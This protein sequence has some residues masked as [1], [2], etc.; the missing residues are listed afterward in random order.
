MSW[1][2]NTF[3]I[4]R[5]AMNTLSTRFRRTLRTGLLAV[6]LAAVTGVAAAPAFA[7]EW[8][9]GGFRHEDGRFDHRHFDH[10]R[11]FYPYRPYAYVA[12]GYLAPPVVPVVPYVNFGLAVR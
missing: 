2:N 1:K 8:R 7:D 5:A 9:H 3:W 12:P 11:F 4:R 6:A 10:D